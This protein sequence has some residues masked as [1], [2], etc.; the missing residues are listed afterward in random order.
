MRRI[1][2]L[3]AGA[4][5]A[6]A[7]VPSVAF[8]QDATTAEEGSDEIVVTARRRE[9]RLQD[10]PIA[11]TAVGGDLIVADNPALFEIAGFE[12]LTTIDGLYDIHGNTA[13]TR[14][15]APP[16]LVSVGSSLQIAANPELETLV[17]LMG[18]APLTGSRPVRP[19]A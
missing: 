6:I 2:Q 16:A 1:T 10:V 19:R 7:A 13:L 8:A 12:A 18:L 14:I 4:A 17:L 9:E 5:L 3:L 15:L 11:V